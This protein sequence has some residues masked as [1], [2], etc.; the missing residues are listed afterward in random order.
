MNAW[1][2]KEVRNIFSELNSS[3]KGL[4]KRDA[5]KRLAKYGKNELERKKKPLVF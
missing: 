5:V 1:H 4:A 3:E 2:A